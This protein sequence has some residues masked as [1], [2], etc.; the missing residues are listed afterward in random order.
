MPKLEVEI[1]ELV[2]EDF[3]NE[4]FV[5]S[6]L[7]MDFV[8]SSAT[9]EELREIFEK[10]KPTT[11]SYVAMVDEELAGFG[12]LLVHYSFTRRNLG[13]PCDVCVLEKFRR[14]GIA[15]KLLETIMFPEEE[16]KRL[17][18]IYGP[19]GKDL[20]PLYENLAFERMDVVYME[21]RL[22]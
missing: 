21:R 2:S 5:K 17:W 3:D 11:K 16:N 4:G 8:D 6:F 12:C 18:R 19:V 1:R 9:G 7:E 22:H 10:R 15:L 14:H 20:I 13:V